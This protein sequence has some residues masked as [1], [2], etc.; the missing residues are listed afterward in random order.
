M[1]R[2]TTSVSFGEQSE[3]NEGLPGWWSTTW[4]GGSWSRRWQFPGSRQEWPP[5]QAEGGKHLYRWGEHPPPLY[6]LVLPQQLQKEKK[7]LPQLSSTIHHQCWSLFE[8]S[9]P[10][11]SG[12]SPLR[13]S[14]KLS[15]V[16]TATELMVKI[17]RK[18]GVRVCHWKESIHQIHEHGEHSNHGV[19][20]MEDTFH[21]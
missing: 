1:Q 3:V 7:R 10:L 15:C 19:W 11:C 2:V 21:T 18:H 8:H 12:N 16:S 14:L 6:H 13:C 17:P 4:E 20:L 5:S 9:P